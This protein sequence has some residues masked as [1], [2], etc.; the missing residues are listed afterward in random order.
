[1]L[2][3]YTN[4]I[5]KADENKIDVIKKGGWIYWKY[6]GWVRKSWGRGWWW[7][8]WIWQLMTQRQIVEEESSI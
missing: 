1:M 7:E 8:I 3:D 2:E 5:P 6:V 4:E